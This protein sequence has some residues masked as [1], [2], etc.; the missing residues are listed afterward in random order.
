M[1]I[2]ATNQHQFATRLH[3]FHGRANPHG[4]G[5]IDPQADE[6]KFIFLVTWQRAVKKPSSN[7][8]CRCTLWRQPWSPAATS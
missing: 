8:P 2:V 4:I 3:S 7:S 5:V 1:K 6:S